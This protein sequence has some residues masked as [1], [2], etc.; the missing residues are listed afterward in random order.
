ME[1]LGKFGVTVR[2][3]GWGYQLYLRV[4]AGPAQ[5]FGRDWLG[6][7][8]LDWSNISAQ[9]KASSVNAISFDRTEE[10]SKLENKHNSLFQSE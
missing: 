4:A 6:V 3:G 2:Y 5:L 9:L 1:V 8:H 7:V 10:I